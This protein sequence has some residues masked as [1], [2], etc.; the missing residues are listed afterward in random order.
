MLAKGLSTG[1][2]AVMAA[3][4]RRRAGALAGGAMILGGSVLMRWAIFKAGAQ[5]ATDPKYTVGPQRRRIE[6]AIKSNGRS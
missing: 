6:R 2:A 1:G 5:S 4:G 3:R